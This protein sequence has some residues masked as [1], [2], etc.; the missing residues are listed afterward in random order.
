MSQH[1]FGLGNGWLPR[2]ANTAAR[3]HGAELVNYTDAQCHC[4]HGCKPHTCREAR[5]H[6]FVCDNY[7]EPFNSNTAARVLDAIEDMRRRA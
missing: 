5:R 6:W 3:K 4:G 1:M 7:G 2:K